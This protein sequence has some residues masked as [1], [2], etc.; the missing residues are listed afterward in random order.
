MATSMEEDL[1]AG[2][3]SSSSSSSVNKEFDLESYISNY[4]GHTKI[5]RLV[6]IAE[7]NKNVELDAYRMAIDTLKS[8]T[9][10]TGLY[11][12]VAER[13]GDRLGPSYKLDQAWIDSTDKKAVQQLERLE[14]DLNNHK[15]NLIKENIRVGHNELGELYYKRGDLNNSLK[16]F[17]RAR[18]YCSNSKHILQMCFNVI[19]VSIEMNNFAH[20]S[21]YVGKAEQTSAE[22]AEPA[23][24]SRLRVCSGL[25]NLENKKYKAAALKF[26]EANFNLGDFNYVLAPQDVAIYGALTALATFDRSELKKKVIDNQVFRNYS[27][28]V[29]EVREMIHDFYGSK[30][31][32]CLAHLE[33][34]KG[35]LLL[36]IHLHDHVESLYQKIRSKALIQYF[37]PFVSV[38][39][40]T[41]AAAF[42]T[43]VSGIEKELAKL[44]MD[45][46]IQARIDSHNKRLYARHTDQ[47]SQTFQN[48]L[49][50]GDEYQ[51]SVN[52]LLM[53]VNLQRSEF[54]VKLPRRDDLGPGVNP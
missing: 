53:R 30:Y 33:K 2:S 37:S 47:R 23:V 48:S 20:V 36:D 49:K 24:Q 29:P 34:L 5:A 7:H 21:N 11:K 8:T 32:S 25:A 52:A 27:E 22:S 18:D 13:V 3:E 26:L 46:S 51:R 1:P 14:I 12:T 43:S 54:I 45:G 50:M 19:R 40:N 6:F 15:A 41:M 31:A 9:Y 16:C 35:D 17:V 4:S 38:D 10:N 39:L 28:L 42:S 44:I